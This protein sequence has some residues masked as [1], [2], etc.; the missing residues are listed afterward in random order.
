L[1]S[2]IFIKV[3]EDDIKRLTNWEALTRSG[4]C[5]RNWLNDSIIRAAFKAK[6]RVFTPA[7]EVSISIILLMYFSQF[8]IS[9]KSFMKLLNTTRRFLMRHLMIKLNPHWRIHGIRLRAFL[10]YLPNNP[11][12]ILKLQAEVLS[13]IKA[14]EGT[15]A[16]WSTH[17][18]VAAWRRCRE[19]KYED[20]TLLEVCLRWVFIILR[21]GWQ[22]YWQ[23]VVCSSNVQT[24]SFG[25]T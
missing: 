24:P 9:Q 19:A 16:N 17:N 5:W 2:T 12:F 23:D 13:V 15:Q 8:R 14:A 3:A 4:Q 20:T 18:Q 22:I 6:E 1:E 10:H 7:E 11:R 25:R 21:D